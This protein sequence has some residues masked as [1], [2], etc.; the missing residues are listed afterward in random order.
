MPNAIAIQPPGMTQVVV[1]TS[2]G[3]DLK[4]TFGAFPITVGK[5]NISRLKAMAVADPPCYARI[6]KDIETHG[7]TVITG[8]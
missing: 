6:I 3:D 4:T 5:G 7:S 8:L 1:K 2:A